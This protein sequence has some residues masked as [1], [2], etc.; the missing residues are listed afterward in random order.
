[1]QS[2]TR[3]RKR[4]RRAP[5]STVAIV[6]IHGHSTAP[7][8]I[9]S[10]VDSQT[11]WRACLWNSR[12]WCEDVNH[13]D[14]YRA[15]GEDQG[16]IT[17]IGEMTTKDRGGPLWV[18]RSTSEH[19]P[20]IAPSWTSITG[21]PVEGQGTWSRLDQ[22]GHQMIG[23]GS[24]GSGLT[25]STS[26]A[27]SPGY[28]AVP[29]KGLINFG[30]WGPKAWARYKPLNPKLSTSQFVAELREIPRLFFE[31]RKGLEF[32]K[33]LGEFYLNVE[34]GWKPFLADLKH[35]FTE[36]VNFNERWAQLL[37]DNGKPV[38]RE[39]PV[40]KDI[41]TTSTTTYSTGSDILSPGY[42]TAAYIKWFG[43]LSNIKCSKT[44]TTTTRQEYWFSGT[45]RYY[46]QPFDTV[47]YQEEIAR[48]IFGVDL[49][50]RLYWEL[51]P[52]SWL[53]DWVSSVGDSI[54]NLTEINLDSL[55]A[56]YAYTMGHYQIE[57]ENVWT[58]GLTVA[59]HVKTDEIKA[60][61]P[62]TPF[63]FGID[64]SSFSLRQ[65]AILAALA[66]ARS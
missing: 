58:N 27:I 51:L 47:R 19:W 11:R 46:L 8:P 49:T 28:N 7:F 12:E 17:L 56:E 16:V 55:V 62:A 21:T 38:H 18:R 26:G 39:G 61:I 64:T 57:V 37:R 36:V 53:A 44:V 10:T 20:G 14:H 6:K 25:S 33:T 15:I 40:W 42:E 23:G 4:D 5:D 3:T 43:S 13:R 22:F 59:R 60:R 50:P 30:L 48:I 66:L 34:F 1:M 41:D 29:S 24:F 63:G 2:P 35:F 54:N 32:F 52:W 31:I 9:G 45:F 65:N